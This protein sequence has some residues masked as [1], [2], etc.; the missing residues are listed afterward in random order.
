M[1]AAEVDKMLGHLRLAAEMDV[2]VCGQHIMSLEALQ[3]YRAGC[4]P[5]DALGTVRRWASRLVV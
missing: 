4:R 3:V 1:Y 5:G 2:Q